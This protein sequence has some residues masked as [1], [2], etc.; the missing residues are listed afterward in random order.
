MFKTLFKASSSL[1][2]PERFG[3]IGEP[4]KYVPETCNELVS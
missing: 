2:L 4:I 3:P 1:Y